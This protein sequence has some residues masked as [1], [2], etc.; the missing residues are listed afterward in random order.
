MYITL[1]VHTFM[2]SRRGWILFYADASRFVRLMMNIYGRLCGLPRGV[3]GFRRA[4]LRGCWS[5]KIILHFINIGN[6]KYI[7]KT[8]V[9]T[10][11]KMFKHKKRSYRYFL[12]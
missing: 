8:T 4:K 7:N 1:C 5:K 12:C 6:K 11:Y 10:D 2:K 3:G 9:K